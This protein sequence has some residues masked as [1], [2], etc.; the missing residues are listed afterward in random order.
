MAAALVI[1][2]EVVVVGRSVGRSAP[3][4]DSSG[5]PGGGLGTA[6]VELY[7][8]DGGPDSRDAPAPA[9]GSQDLGF[10]GS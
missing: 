7:A 10:W 9:Q 2:V 4:S 8:A 5:I 3:V 1:M 6:V